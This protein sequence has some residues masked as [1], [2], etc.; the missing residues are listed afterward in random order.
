[1]IKIGITGGIGSGK[2]IVSRL[3]EMLGIPVYIAD[4][5]AK[6]ITSDSSEVKKK[7]T[8]LFGENTYPNGILDKQYLASIIF[9]NPVAL[10]QTNAIIHPEVRKDFEKW[11]NHQHVPVVAMEAAI[12]FEAGFD[13]DMD[14][15]IVVT[16][17]TDIRIKRVTKRDNISKEKV[18]ERINN[19]ITDEDKIKQSDFQIINDDKIPIIPQICK[20]VDEIR[21]EY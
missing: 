11:A 4:A 15:L 8:D 1:M 16:A 18:M 7:L 17:P 12:L 9:N 21:A 5:E 13:K 19:Q 3:F 20:I 6:K 2:S 14:K 10:S